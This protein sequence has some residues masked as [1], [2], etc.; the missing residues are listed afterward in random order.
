MRDSRSILLWIFFIVI[1]PITK[2]LHDTPHLY[3][4]SLS[5]WPDINLLAP[6]T[7]NNSSIFIPLYHSILRIFSTHLFCSLP[8]IYEI[9]ISCNTHVIIINMLDIDINPWLYVCIHPTVSFNSPRVF[10]IKPIYSLLRL[11]DKVVIDCLITS[12]IP[13]LHFFFSLLSSA[14][15]EQ[16]IF[17]FNIYPSIILCA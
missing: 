14:I 7:M 8:S 1:L 11:L 16:Y 3:K 4:P 2:I 13:L 5:T 6:F 17:T 15:P 9:I 10:I 12:T